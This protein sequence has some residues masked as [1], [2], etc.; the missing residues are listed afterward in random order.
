MP[1]RIIQLV[2]RL[3]VGGVSQ[4]VEALASGLSSRGWQVLVVYGTVEPHENDAGERLRRAGL[5]TLHVSALRRP[6]SARRDL[7]AWWALRG[8]F[9]THRPHLVHTHMSK[10]G[11]IGWLATRST[12]PK[13]RPATVHTFHGHVLDGYFGSTGSRVTAAIE[14]VMRARTDRNV[15]LSEQLWRELVDRHRVFPP[16]RACLIPL[17]VA[18]AELPAQA[19]AR[20]ALGLRPEHFVIGFVGRLTAV[21]NPLLLV[22]GF[23]QMARTVPN[24]HLVVAGDGELKPLVL[25]RVHALAL[26]DRVHLVGVRPDIATVYGA[27]DVLAVT[28]D[29]EG[30]PVSILEAMAF[31]RPVI[32][33][34][35]GG[36][37]DL[38]SDGLTGRLVARGSVDE[39][40]AAF[41]AFAASPEAIK[42][43]GEA[44]RCQ[45]RARHTIPAMLDRHESLYRELLRPAASPGVPR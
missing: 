40:A 14:R 4:H 42:A 43:M 21:K 5:Q 33:T 44:G 30:T 37:R 35:V 1:E 8:I 12:V 19:H 6:I 3:N 32:A 26:G 18:A 10:A 9:S 16:E 2:T 45:V 25:S 17:G 20:E 29:Q 36:N 15:V 27:M 22:N 23:A 41:T 7:E 31:G 13:L 39:L 38:V 28:S 24:A 34:D 11:A